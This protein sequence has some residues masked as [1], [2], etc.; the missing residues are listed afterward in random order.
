MIISEKNQEKLSI[1]ACIALFMSLGVNSFAVEDASPGISVIINE[2]TVDFKNAKP[3]M[4][5]SRV[6]VPLRAFF[7]ALGATVT[8]DDLKQ[9]ITAVRDDITTKLVIGSTTM[10]KTDKGISSSVQMDAAPF[11]DG[12]YTM[13]PA[14]YAA[15]AFGCEIGWDYAAQTVLIFDLDGL[16]K[17]S[18]AHYTLINK[19]MKLVSDKV[20][21]NCSYDGNMYRS[22]ENENGAISKI[23]LTFSGIESKD[24]ANLSIKLDMSKYVDAVGGVYETSVPRNILDSKLPYA[25]LKYIHDKNSAQN[26]PYPKVYFQSPQMSGLYKI[27][28]DAWISLS[29]GGYP[30][31]WSMAPHSTLRTSPFGGARRPES[32][33][34]GYLKMINGGLDFNSKDKLQRVIRSNKLWNAIYSD[35]SFKKDGDTYTNKFTKEEEE[36]GTTTDFGFV[37][38]LQN[39]QIAAYSYMRID[40]NGEY[41]SEYLS[42]MDA[43]GNYLVRSNSDKFDR[44]LAVKIKDTDEYPLSKPQ[45]GKIYDEE[46]LKS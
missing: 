25:E 45:S 17:S 14:S 2:S 28:S 43:S 22:I 13:I 40:T 46:S 34:M 15:S 9:T 7:E 3:V 18:G 11:I 12:D 30:D 35:E 6:Y 20:G 33:F 31:V 19:F 26:Y 1:F 44:Y 32:D 37:I 36:N 24:A 21:G 27:E 8:Y 4:L 10:T 29:R 42:S 5:N 41:K 16:I 39:D 23:S 38:T